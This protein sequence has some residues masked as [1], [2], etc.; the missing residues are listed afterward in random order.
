MTYKVTQA[1]RDLKD[2]QHYYRAGD[3][4]PR[5]GLKVDDERVAE[6]VKGGYIVADVEEDADL[7]KLKKDELVALAVEKGIEVDTKDTK[8]EIIEKLEV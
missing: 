5:E 3:V 8:A 6:L 2:N 7:S 4:F 1:I